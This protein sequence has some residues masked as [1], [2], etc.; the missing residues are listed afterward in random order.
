MS[1]NVYDMRI[2]GKM[3]PDMTSKLNFGK[4]AALPVEKKFKI[5]DSEYKKILNSK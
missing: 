3:P 5:F 4:Y 1:P 2:V